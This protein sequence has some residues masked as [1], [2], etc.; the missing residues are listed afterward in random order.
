MSIPNKR[1]ERRASKAL[2]HPSLN[3]TLSSLVGDLGWASRLAGIIIG[4][5]QGQDVQLSVKGKGKG[6]KV[7]GWMEE[8]ELEREGS[9]MAPEDGKGRRKIGGNGISNES[10]SDHTGGKRPLLTPSSKLVSKVPRPSRSLTGASGVRN[11]FGSQKKYIYGTGKRRTPG[12]YVKREGIT[13]KSRDGQVSQ[14]G[15]PHKRQG[16]RPIEWGRARIWFGWRGTTTELWRNRIE[17][18]PPD[19]KTAQSGYLELELI[20]C[21]NRCSSIDH[22][23][24]ESLCPNPVGWRTRRVVWRDEIVAWVTIGRKATL[25]STIH[26]IVRYM[27]CFNDERLV[28]TLMGIDFSLSRVGDLDLSTLAEAGEDWGWGVR[29]PIEVIWVAEAGCCRRERLRA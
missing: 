28:L 26:E 6:V 3:E 19:L 5:G 9:L 16:V 11:N 13:R 4:V 2:L 10:T 17:F 7:K 24:S 18:E 22:L 12:R 20:T 29:P 21:C 27:N 15:S 8:E 1:K 25:E 14:Y 23:H